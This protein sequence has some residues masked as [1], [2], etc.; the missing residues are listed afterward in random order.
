MQD[1]I[2]I[3][4]SPPEEDCAQLGRDGYW[5]QATRECRAYINQLRR[6]L[7]EEPGGARLAIKSHEHDFGTYL[8]VCCYFDDSIGDA[9]EYAYRC[10]AQ[11]PKTWDDQARA[12]L[13]SLKR[14]TKKERR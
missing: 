13:R 3:G 14:K 7:G 6:A 11:S 5:E 1:W 10:E 12:E 2:D 4:S 9:V 8:S